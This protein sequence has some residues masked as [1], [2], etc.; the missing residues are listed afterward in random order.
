MRPISFA[1]LRLPKEKAPV[2]PGCS[3][4][5]FESKAG[6]KAVDPVEV[7][8][9]TRQEKLRRVYHRHEIQWSGCKPAPLRKPRDCHT[10]EKCGFAREFQDV[11]RQR[12]HRHL[13]WT[14]GEYFRASQRPVTL[15]EGV[16]SRRQHVAAHPVSLLRVG[17]WLAKGAVGAQLV[18]GLQR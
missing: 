5:R 17:Q 14:A 2:Q 12:T 3:Q 18:V 8:P 9:R 6:I 15:E 16:Q 10:G 13:F 4:E 11:V 7:M 1:Q